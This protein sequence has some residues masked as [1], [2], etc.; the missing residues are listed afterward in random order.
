MLNI[1]KLNQSIVTVV[2]AAIVFCAS[3]PTSRAEVTEDYVNGL[4][5]LPRN[6]SSNPWGA[7]D[8]STT[9]PE[10][11]V[12][13][14]KVNTSSLVTTTTTPPSNVTIEMPALPRSRSAENA[15]F[16]TTTSD[17]SLSDKGE[18][19][20]QRCFAQNK[21]GYWDGKNCNC[22]NDE[23]T[24]QNDKR[25]YEVNQNQGE[26]RSNL[27]GAQTTYKKALSTYNTEK[28][29]YEQELKRLTQDY[30]NCPDKQCRKKVQGSIAT[31][32]STWAEQ[33]NTLVDSIMKAQE[34]V[35]DAEDAYYNRDVVEG[36]KNSAGNAVQS[37]KTT[38]NE[39]AAKVNAAQARLDK[40]N[41]GKECVDS[42][43]NATTKDALEQEVETLKSEADA[44]Y[45]AY[46]TGQNQLNAKRDRLG[47]AVNEAQAEYQKA[48]N[49]YTHAANTCKFYET[50]SRVSDAAKKEFN[51]YCNADGSVKNEFKR[52]LA[53]A[54]ENLSYARDQ[55]AEVGAVNT[56]EHK[57]QIYLAVS[58]DKGKHG[59][60]GIFDGKYVGSAT[61]SAGGG[62]VFS[63]IA[64]RAMRFLV[65][66][67]PIIYL[68]AGFGLIGFAWMAIFN[69][70]SFKWFSQI[71]IGLFLVAN[72][73]RFIEYFVYQRTDAS[74][75][76]PLSYG[77]YLHKGFADTDY[78]WVKESTLYSPTYNAE[79]PDA[80]P[81]KEGT[82]SKATRGFCQKA[83]PEVSGWGGFTSCVKDIISTGKKAVDTVKTAQNTINNVKSGIEA[84]KAAVRNVGDAVK[85]ITSAGSLEGA[86]NA[87]GKIGANVNNV[88]GTAGGLV[89][90]TLAN[91]SS[92]SNSIQD[93]GSSTDE[94]AARDT[95]RAR[96]EGTNDFDRMLKG[97]TVGANGEVE[98]LYGGTDQHGNVQQGKIATSSNGVSTVSDVTKKIVQ[99]SNKANTL[100]QKGTNVA[101]EAASVVGNTSLNTITAGIVKNDSTINGAIQDHKQSSTNSRANT[102]SRTNSATTTNGRR[103]NSTAASSGSTTGNRP[104]STTASGSSNGNSTATEAAARRAAETAKEA[105]KL[106]NEYAAN[107]TPDK[108][109]D[110]ASAKAA[111]AQATA[112]RAEQEAQRKQ[113]EADKAQAV[114]DTAAQK[115]KASGK[116]SDLRA[117]E[118]AQKRADLATESAKTAAKEAKEAQK[119]VAALQES[120]REAEVKRAQYQQEQYQQEMT[121]AQ[122]AIVLARSA[123]ATAE[124]KAK[125]LETAASEAAKKAALSN[126]DEDVVAA[127]KA[128][129]LARK[130]RKDAQAAQ[131]NI[132][133]QIVRRNEAELNYYAAKTKE[134][135]LNEQK[136]SYKAGGKNDY[137]PDYLYSGTSSD[138]SGATA[139]SGSTTDDSTTPTTST[140]T[141]GRSPDSAAVSSSTATTPAKS[142]ASTGAAAPSKSSAQTQSTTATTRSVSVTPSDSAADTG[143]STDKANTNTASG[144]TSSGT[145]GNSTA[146]SSS[147]GSSGG[148][149]V[150]NSTGGSKSTTTGSN[151][152]SSSSNKSTG[153]N[154][155]EAATTASSGSQSSGKTTSVT[156]SSSRIVIPQRTTSISTSRSSGTSRSYNTNI[157]KYGTASQAS[158]SSTSA[159]N[160]GKQAIGT[161]G[162]NPNS[163]A[164]TAARAAA[165]KSKQQQLIRKQAEEKEM[166]EK[167]A[168]AKALALQHEM[169]EQEMQRRWKRDD[170][171]NIRQIRIGV[172]MRN[173]KA[174][175]DKKEKEA[176]EAEEKQE[177]KNQQPDTVTVSGDLAPNTVIEEAK[178]QAQNNNA[179]KAKTDSQSS[180]AK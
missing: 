12:N 96:G 111:Q 75:V 139:S 165:F 25:L 34:G 122:N 73:G 43:G 40:C 95:K 106:R 94:V 92:I 177:N 161:G 159:S 131:K 31:H 80:I 27:E 146:S 77:D 128:A 87:L 114:A 89:N 93:I 170:E 36:A 171:E 103:P 6:S 155:K 47:K 86:V 28:Y 49:A 74:A 167:Q 35:T 129:E 173:L 164:A 60:K 30:N 108:L 141:T 151:L 11:Y 7:N 51:Q 76:Q 88:I 38:Y 67:K 147:G 180:T 56:Y 115:A 98:R 137:S 63:Q 83:S 174:L 117:A 176:K 82:G 9:R 145:S 1:R 140:T 138:N 57:D 21:K 64:A 124:A 157:Y 113:Q 142:S 26:L 91:A 163:A 179:A 175:N 112:T 62:N 5:Y 102:A 132:E 23:A 121:D 149:L 3:A 123:A 24:F 79:S 100:L 10:G 169:A 81:G 68:L 172:Q 44:A 58:T 50:N 158:A 99:E 119:P 15:F 84:T 150:S 48:L 70:I 153:S 8:T 19:C 120:A 59:T 143:R 166:R 46:R 54:E 134:A 71:A 18:E 39:A 130:A 41:S 127:R 14:T 133:E 29:K 156:G 154:T 20:S 42:N 90:N 22:I 126:S 101:A 125:E 45:S 136:G 116:A 160:E 168:E 2:L 16:D 66:I 37:L 104:N 178:A 55:A 107:T 65:G 72:M 105:E 97:Q 53:S 85:G 52:A 32:K 78:E 162:V 4:M 13:P 152:V 61:Y 148:H 17:A 110:K 33:N 69:K 109:A 144:N 135:E 118:Q